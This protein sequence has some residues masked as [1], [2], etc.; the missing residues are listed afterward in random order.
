MLSALFF[1]LFLGNTITTS[2]VIPQKLSEGLQAKS[3][4]APQVCVKMNFVELRPHQHGTTSM[5]MVATVSC[6]N[7]YKFISG[8]KQVINGKYRFPTFPS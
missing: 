7:C 8:V 5:V 4:K 2:M 3:S 6:L 1:F